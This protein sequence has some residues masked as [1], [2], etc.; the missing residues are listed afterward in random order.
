MLL[1]TT[2]N[3]PLQGEIPIPLAT[4]DEDESHK[5]GCVSIYM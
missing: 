4:T 3:N 2:L 5:E 1:Q